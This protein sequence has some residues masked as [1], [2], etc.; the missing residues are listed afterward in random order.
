MATATSPG[1]GELP[2]PM[3]LGDR[4]RVMRSSGLGIWSRRGAAARDRLSPARCGS[5]SA[6]TAEDLVVLRTRC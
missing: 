3:S 6:F 2:P 5:T 4:N 1:R